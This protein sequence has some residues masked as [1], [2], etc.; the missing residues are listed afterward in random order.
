MRGDSF[1][2]LIRSSLVHHP[3]SKLTTHPERDLT[4]ILAEQ[5]TLEVSCV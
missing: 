2:P 5:P 4:M 3:I 1:N